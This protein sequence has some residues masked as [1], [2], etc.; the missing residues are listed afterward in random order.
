MSTLLIRQARL[1]PVGPGVTAGPSP[2]PVDVVVTDGRVTA[3]GPDLP[4]HPG[5]TAAEVVDAEG[6][7]LIPGLWDQHVHLGQWTL[8]SQ[9]LDL[10]GARS[11]E[12]A[13]RMV[14]ERLAEQPGHP[15]I[16]WGHRSGGWERDV[17]VSELDAVSG[18]TPVVLISGDGHH[19]WLNTTA[20][21]HL[22]MPVRDSVVRE[23]EWFAAYARLSTLVG[24]D[25]T[26]PAAY[27]RALDTA[28]SLGVVGLVDLEFSGGA[29]DWLHRW[30]QGCDRLR[31]RM[32]T[33]AEG[34]DQ[35][36]SLGLRTGDVLPGVADVTGPHDDRL[37][38]G[39]LKIISDGSLNTR[40]AWCCEPYAD[41]HRLEYPAGQPNLSGAE[42]R[43]LLERAHAAGLEVATHAI[44]DAA[45]AAA[46]AAYATTGARGSIEHA[47]M[48]G[49]ADSRRMAELGIRAS[50]Q[51]AHLLDD[52]DLT[53]KIWQERASRCFAFRWMLDDG[54]EL[55]L[56]S[57]APVSPLDPW[58]AMAAA[59][60]RSA[61]EREPWHGEQALTVAEALAASTDGWGTVAPGHPGDLVLLDA[62]PYAAFGSTAE[63]GAWLREMPVA[64]TYVAGEAVYGAGIELG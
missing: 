18:D 6:R 38:M 49:R 17:T 62:D 29:A 51:P 1:V 35:V 15:V 32:S 19:A 64:A 45:V 4:V 48:V 44:G 23:A 14:A 47:Q 39:P 53:E 54:V 22:A 61:D 56:G 24:D 57:D 8:A 20:L 60:H 28:A 27:R 26:S 31:V 41:A 3:V 63:Q 59:V 58:L 42:L 46:L 12:D 5:A 36:L 25:G 10:A 16:G 40:T 34:L 33:Y 11:P 37:Q 55:V 50:V 30:E 43:S 52:R 2:R 21:L 7:W 13:T 9:R